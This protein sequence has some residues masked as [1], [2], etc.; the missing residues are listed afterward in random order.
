MILLIVFTATVG[1]FLEFPAAAEF[2]QSDAPAWAALVVVGYMATAIPG[3]GYREYQ[4]GSRLLKDLTEEAER[5]EAA[6]KQAEF[7][8]S[9]EAPPVGGA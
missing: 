8:K 3:Q 2:L 4:E 1:S 6:G 7:A 5:A 9:Q